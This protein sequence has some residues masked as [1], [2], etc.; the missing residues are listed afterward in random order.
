MSANTL[1]R[2]AAAPR[3]DPEQRCSPEEWMQAIYRVHAQPLFKY[4]LR[5]TLGDR[6][7]AE[8]LLQ[9]TLLRAWRNIDRLPPDLASVRPWLFTVA[10]NHAIDLARA[11]QARPAVVATED[12]SREPA[13]GDAVERVVLAQTVH[14][15]LSKLSEDHRVVLVELYLRGASAAEAAGRIGIPEG[16]VKSRAHYALRA[17]RV[18]LG[19][20]AW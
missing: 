10:R 13:P 8:D 20:R 9:E 6:Q 4:L 17:L 11:R 3:P 1:A 15:A 14:K 18:A 5:L 2:P 7:A 19:P 12:M 16:T